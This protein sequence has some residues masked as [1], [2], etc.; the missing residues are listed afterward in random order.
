MSHNIQD[1]IENATSKY[2]L[3]CSIL[4]D[5]SGRVSYVINGEQ[6]LP[7]QAV[8]KFVDEGWSATYHDIA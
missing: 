2:G 8:D 5:E 6:Y 7:Y 4:K 3:S 1:A